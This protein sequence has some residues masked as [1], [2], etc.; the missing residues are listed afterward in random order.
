M[1][2]KVIVTFAGVSIQEFLSKGLINNYDKSKVGNEVTQTE[3]IPPINLNC[4]KNKSHSNN[5]NNNCNGDKMSDGE[6]WL[7]N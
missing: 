6:Q 4:A 3:K 7:D 1:R 2:V 5:C